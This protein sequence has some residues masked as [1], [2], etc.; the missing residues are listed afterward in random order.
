MFYFQTAE[1]CVHTDATMSS[2]TFSLFAVPG[3][4]RWNAGVLILV[5]AT[6]NLVA[7]TDSHF[8]SQ[9]YNVKLLSQTEHDPLEELMV[10]L[11][12]EQKFVKSNICDRLKT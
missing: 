5:T 7:V 2:S 6:G 3:G 10:Q 11:K 8:V 9:H 12:S 1:V 4:E